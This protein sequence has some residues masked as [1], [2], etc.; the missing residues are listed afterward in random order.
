ME[1]RA[2]RIP[3]HPPRI[4]LAE[5]ATGEGLEQAFAGAE[6]FLSTTVTLADG[7]EVTLYWIN[8]MAKTERLNDYI[9]RPL[10]IL[11]LGKN[12]AKAMQTGGIWTMV[13]EEQ[14]HLEAACTALTEG[15]CAVAVGKKLLLVPV[16]TE[17]KRSITAPEDEPSQKGAKDSFVE[18]LR[19]NT[20][21]IRRHL[22]TWR[23]RIKSVTVGRES[24]TKVEILWIDGI[25]DPALVE[26]AQTGIGQ[27]DVDALMGTQMLTDSL[28]EG[29][30]TLFPLVI[31]TQRP[32]KF[33]RG[34]LDGRVGVLCDG[35]AQGW[36]APGTVGPY[37]RAPQDRNNQWIVIRF[38]LAVRY[39]CVAVSLL[40]P[41]GYISMA[42]FHFGLM[43]AGM[44]ETVSAARQNVPLSPPLEVVVLLLA[45]EILQEAGLRL[46]QLNGQSVSIIGSLV[47]GQ[48]AVEAKLLSPVVVV[49]IAAAGVAGYTLP[50]Q[51]LANALRLVRLS[52]AVLA[53]FFGI[54]GVIL[55]LVW[56]GCHLAELTPLGVPWLAPFAPDVPKSACDVARVPVRSVKFRELFLHPRD[57]RS[58]K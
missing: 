19:T 29:W 9:I 4:R 6:D 26:R 48:A 25:T 51:D 33:C 52:L 8:G 49:V 14:E 31:T 16:P 20:S 43:P 22:H 10:T 57:K 28:T 30:R 34:L 56:L 44:A 27:M 21:L 36:L 37:F 42:A 12:P 38:L 2:V 7:G 55:G 15:S 46:P 40:L 45:F 3:Y 13:A 17:E 35:I 39:L 50:D 24:K 58:Q 32:D 5:R 54:V 1:V 47:V 11:H 53:S 23:L 41:A 18:T